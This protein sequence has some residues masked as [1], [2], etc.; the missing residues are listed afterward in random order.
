MKICQIALQICPSWLKIFPIN[1]Y[2]D[3]FRDLFFIKSGDATAA[4]TLGETQAKMFC[5]HGNKFLGE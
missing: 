4:K 2:S 5:D 1:K 3:I